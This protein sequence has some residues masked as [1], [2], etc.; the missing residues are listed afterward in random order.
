MMG[1]FGPEEMSHPVVLA[2]TC[3][4]LRSASA[5]AVNGSMGCG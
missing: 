2:D 1:E 4:D 5:A 3:C